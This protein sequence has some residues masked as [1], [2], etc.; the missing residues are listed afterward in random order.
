MKTILLII[1]TLTLSISAQEEVSKKVTA[2]AGIGYRS[3]SWYKWEKSW[4]TR[5]SY[6]TETSTHTIIE[7]DITIPKISTRIGFNLQ[8]E[9]GSLDK[10]KQYS[11]YIG[12][13]NIKIK[14]ERGK[15][16]GS[17]NYSGPVS[18]EQS[19]NMNY[20]QVYTYT[21]L[22]FNIPQ[23]PSGSD[24]EFDYM[25]FRYTKWNLPSLVYL[26]QEGGSYH[27]VLDGDFQT[28][29][30]TFFIGKDSFTRDLLYSP[31]KW[32]PSWAKMISYTLGAGYGSSKHG[33]KAIRAAKSIYGLTV[34]EKTNAIIAGHIS[35]QFGVMYG[36][37][38]YDAKIMIGLGYDANFLFL[39]KSPFSHFDVPA[40]DSGRADM[41]TFP[42]FIYHGP[43]LRVHGT[44]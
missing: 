34:T 21:E 43:I 25:G 24:P 6:D 31:E 28:E 39:G 32:K 12:Y 3:T 22:S 44:F 36:I 11:G 33:D 16:A 10:V 15:F 9:S 4:E 26:V 23:L 42:M 41:S 13:K 5:T 7:G 27:A 1:L 30:Y 40:D 8:H 19:A 38:V 29:F 20:D 2:S 17:I 37:K 35:G 18:A 14:T